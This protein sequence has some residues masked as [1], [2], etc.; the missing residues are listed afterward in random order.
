M[1]K[2]CH[3]AIFVE[4]AVTGLVSKIQ[5]LIDLYLNNISTM[6]S[7]KHRTM[8]HVATFMGL[9]DST[10]LAQ[11]VKSM[12]KMPLRDILAALEDNVGAE[13]LGFSVQDCEDDQQLLEAMAT[14]SPKLRYLSYLIAMITLILGTKVLVWTQFPWP[15][16]LIKKYLETAGVD[17]VSIDANMNATQRDTVIND[18]NEFSDR[19]MV[20][21]TTY[22]ISAEAINLQKRCHYAVF[23][24]PAVSLQQ[25]LQALSR[26]RRFGQT[27][28]QY[29][30]NLYLNNINELQDGHMVLITTY[31]IS[32]E[33]INLQKRC[34]Y[35]VFV[36]PA[37]DN[38][39]KKV[40]PELIA[41]I[42]RDGELDGGYL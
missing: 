30:I 3:Y 14:E 5:H 27:E 26:I 16:F 1:Q 11:H 17:V 34:Y 24:E 31:D 35:A 23:V 13:K 39:T 33:A 15:A 12:Y 42:R 6:D 8:C 38:Q 25:F 40:L 37:I 9:Q 20:L 18:F 28:T 41:N 2:R 21:V 22:D 29:W 4:P 7:T 19:H 10:F 32:A 36:E